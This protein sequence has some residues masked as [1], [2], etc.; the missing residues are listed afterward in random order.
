LQRLKGYLSEA[1]AKGTEIV[2]LYPEA[3]MHFLTG[4][5]A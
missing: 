5:A 3:R 4:L 2:S 1:E